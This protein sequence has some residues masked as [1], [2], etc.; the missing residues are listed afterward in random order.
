M[1]RHPAPPVKTR[2]EVLESAAFTLCKAATLILLTGRWALVV[3]AGGAAIL[4][5]LADYH[6]KKDTRCLLLHPKLIAA[7]W[8]AVAFV[9]GFYQW[10]GGRWR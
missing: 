9:S 4:Y 1:T 8:G 10:H 6:G 5:L 3:A 2:G 7:L